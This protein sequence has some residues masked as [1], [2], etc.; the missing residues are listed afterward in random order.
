MTIEFQQHRRIQSDEPDGLAHPRQVIAAIARGELVVIVD[1]ENRE[2]EGDLV[3][4]ADFA[5]AKAINFMITHGRGLVCLSLT[6]ERASELHLPPMVQH[7]QDYMGT[8]FTVSI[9]GS[10]ENGVRTGISAGERARTIELARCGEATDLV[11]PGHVFPLI[12]RSGGVL[13]RP[14]HTEASVDL[15]RLAGLTPAG[16]IVEI[17]GEDG[18]MLRLPALRAF[19]ERHGLLISS[20]ERLQEHLREQSA[21]A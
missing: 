4:A 1:D 2:N 3:V 8:A 17:I 19:A 7:N 10:R 15:A 12:A 16:V 6:E 9:D 18:E 14:G 5:D 13:E 20:I 11:R 21:A